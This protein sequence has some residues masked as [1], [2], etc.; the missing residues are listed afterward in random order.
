M[1]GNIDDVARQAVELLG[2]AKITEHLDRF[3]SLIEECD[4]LAGESDELFVE[5]AIRRIEPLIH[6]LSTRERLVNALE[7][8]IEGH[9][10][11]RADALAVLLMLALID[12]VNRIDAVSGGPWRRVR[13]RVDRLKRAAQSG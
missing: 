13:A 8:I 1:R 6:Y 11:P 10:N 2:E 12:V 7:W 5:F 9:S 4:G 3:R